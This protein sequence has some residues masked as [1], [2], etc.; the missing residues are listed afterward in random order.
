M[1]S[2]P[3]SESGSFEVKVK[4][5]QSWAETVCKAKEEGLR[6][7]KQMEEEDHRFVLKVL[8]PREMEEE[9]TIPLSGVV[10]PLNWK[11]AKRLTMVESA[12]D[13][14]TSAYLLGSLDPMLPIALGSIIEGKGLYK[15]SVGEFFELY[16]QFE[17]KH[18]LKNEKQTKAKMTALINGDMKYLKS[19]KARDNSGKL[20]LHPLPFAVRNILAHS[21]RTSNRLD[22]KGVELET[23]IELLLSWV[24]PKK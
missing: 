11:V 18:K 6:M 10:L 12:K 3:H 4:T 20:E 16:G 21:G 23:S 8:G 13:L 5:K 17:G 2:V 9:D 7:A 15:Y 1:D 24:H 19:I 22:R 14:I